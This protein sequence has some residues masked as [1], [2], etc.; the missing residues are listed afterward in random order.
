MNKYLKKEKNIIEKI[1]S[2]ANYEE[3]DEDILIGIVENITNEKISKKELLE[4]IVTL[5]LNGIS[6]GELEELKHFQI[7]ELFDSCNTE[8]FRET[9]S[10]IYDL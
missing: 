10:N 3:G 1:R 7:I 9:Y 5:Y 4:Q 6:T 2:Y 8:D